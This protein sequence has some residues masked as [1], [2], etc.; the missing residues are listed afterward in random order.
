M[1]PRRAPLVSVQGHDVVATFHENVFDEHTQKAMDALDTASTDS[2]MRAALSP[3]VGRLATIF[4]AL[5][6]YAAAYQFHSSVTKFFGRK[7]TVE[8]DL[9]THVFP[10][11]HPD[12]GKVVK[13]TVSWNKVK[14]LKDMLDA[15]CCVS[16]VIEDKPGDQVSASE[17]WICH[18]LASAC[19]IL[20]HPCG[21]F[22]LCTSSKE[23]LS[24][25]WAGISPYS[26]LCLSHTT[27]MA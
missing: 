3:V 16:E 18:S 2:E 1:P 17:G 7:Y 25:S 5:V 24:W 22:I 15:W 14:S 6:P 8:R 9:G 21:S 20:W 19:C 27:I 11:N 26:A 13:V 4:S 12:S 10:L 23:R